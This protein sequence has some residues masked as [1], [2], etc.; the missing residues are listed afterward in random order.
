MNLLKLCYSLCFLAII[1]VTNTTAEYIEGIDTTDENG[2]G[3]DSGFK[4]TNSLISGQNIAKYGRQ[5]RYS[6]GAFNYSF[7]EIK[8]G[9]D[10]VYFA[11]LTSFNAEDSFNYS[12][13][14]IKIGP[15]SVYFAYP[16]SINI[17]DSFN[18]FV[19]KK[20]I[21]STYSK[22]QFISRL[23]GNRYIYRYGTNTTP[24]NR[25]LEK[26]DYDRSVKYKPNNFYYIASGANLFSWEP[27]LQN[28]NHLI[29]YILFIQK[30]GVTIDTTAPINLSQWDSVGFT[31]STIMSFTYSSPYGEY[32]NLVAV[33]TEGKS[34][35]LKGWTQ[36]LVPMNIMSSKT[37]NRLG[38]YLLIYNT[39][40][41]LSIS[42]N[43]AITRN[44]LSIF[45]VSGRC[46]ANLQYTG[47]RIF[48]NASQQ[49]IPTGIYLLR[50]E[51]PDRSVITK[52]F[53]I[54]R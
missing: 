31:D 25:L 23:A 5:A 48:W 18:C 9:A 38:N 27:P 37:Y 50:A 39:A 52:P 4:V 11:H 46:F 7:D 8:I 42:L 30:K 34:D 19:I 26:P 36:L 43:Q 21:D 14:K 54:T 53:S 22:I 6:F 24:N 33:Y 10:S 20:N 12:F 2:Y 47:S 16:S 17:E 28:D 51:F 35:F 3:L 13:D 40:D 1:L 29:G 44:S 15:D 45:S 41:G 32:F 49:N